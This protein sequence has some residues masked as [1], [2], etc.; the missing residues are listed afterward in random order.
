MENL[1]RRKVDS[2]PRFYLALLIFLAVCALAL[3]FLNTA[4]RFNPVLTEE[5]VG[6][7]YI[8]S[9]RGTCLLLV[10]AGALSMAALLRRGLVLAPLLWLSA[11]L[12]GVVTGAWTEGT[13][14]LLFV[15]PL[16]NLILLAL[17]PILLA[18]LLWLGLARLDP[19]TRVGRLVPGLWAALALSVYACNY[20]AWRWSLTLG[21]WTWPSG[22]TLVYLAGSLIYIAGTAARAPRPALFSYYLG[23]LGPLGANM[24]LLGGYRGFYAFLLFSQPLAGSNPFVLWLGLMLLGVAPALLAL[25]L[26][27]FISWRRGKKLIALV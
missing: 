14:Y 13:R 15:S 17:A 1:L 9:L 11:L 3:I 21:C 27:Q 7:G 5:G 23:F 6:A 19:E 18:L 4:A 22:F 10:T 2:W 16:Y 8:S 26:N 24:L 20:F 12:P 25:A